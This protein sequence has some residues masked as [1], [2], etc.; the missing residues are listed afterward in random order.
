MFD[1]FVELALKEIIANFPF[2][3]SL[4]HLMREITRAYAST[5]A[6]SLMRVKKKHAPLLFMTLIVWDLGMKKNE[7]IKHQIE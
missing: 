2:L 3:S 6:P 1:H 4:I 7:N 5:C